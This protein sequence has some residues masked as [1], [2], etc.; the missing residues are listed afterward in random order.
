MSPAAVAIDAIEI[1]ENTPPLVDWVADKEN[2][3]RFWL[4]ATIEEWMNK[5]G[6]QKPNN[7]RRVETDYR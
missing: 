5:P 4:S 3:L 1:A 6:R 7:G 2:Y